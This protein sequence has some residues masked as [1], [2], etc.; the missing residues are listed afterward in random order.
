MGESVS[1]QGDDFLLTFY[2]E[3][4]DSLFEIGEWETELVCAVCGGSLKKE[5]SCLFHQE[6]PTENT[7]RRNLALADARCPHC[8]ATGSIEQISE[9]TSLF[10]PVATKE[11]WF[12]WL[13]IDPPTKMVK[14]LFGYEEIPQVQRRIKE[15]RRS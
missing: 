14:K 2:R 15:Y 8:L 3:N 11:V 12:R 9:S 6:F 13:T 5:A 4:P 1:E 10:S 7:R